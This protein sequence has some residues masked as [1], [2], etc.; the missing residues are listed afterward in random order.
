MFNV[1][2][3]ITSTKSSRTFKHSAKN[4]LCSVYTLYLVA[5][6]DHPIITDHEDGSVV[7]AE[8]GV[9]LTLTCR[10]DC[11]KPPFQLAWTKTPPIGAVRNITSGTRY[12]T[13]ACTFQDYMNVVS[14]LTYTPQQDDDNTTLTCIDTYMRQPDLV[15]CP[16]K[17]TVAAYGEV[18][19]VTLSEPEFS[20][21]LGFQL[22]IT[23]TYGT[24][25]TSLRWGEH[26]VEYT[27]RNTYNDRET[28]Y[29]F[30]V[31]VTRKSLL[32]RKTR[33]T[34]SSDMPEIVGYRNGS[35]APVKVGNPI[36]LVCIA[37]H[38]DSPV[39]LTWTNSTHEIHEGTRYY[40]EPHDFRNLTNAVN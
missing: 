29:A 31:D 16:A 1:M 2:L 33:V 25:S 13:E 37:A 40:T 39:T 8:V 20:E 26:R 14:V 5:P 28:A 22:N 9:P 27:A 19:N 6:L 18:T 4:A 7:S 35:T 23:S 12:N 32:K 10:A 30:H 17:I 15:I 21:S 34:A 38:G 24:N 11:C 36:T 3:V